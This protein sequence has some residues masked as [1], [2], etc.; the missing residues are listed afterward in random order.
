MYCIVNKQIRGYQSSITS[1]NVVCGPSGPHSELLSPGLEESLLSVSE[2]LYISHMPLLSI[3]MKT[4]VVQHVPR[5]DF[6]SPVR[7]IHQYLWLIDWLNRH[8]D[9]RRQRQS[10]FPDFVKNIWHFLVHNLPLKRQLC[11]KVLT[12]PPSYKNKSCRMTESQTDR[13]AWRQPS[14]KTARQAARLQC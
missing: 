4:K 14:S 13:Q 11:K 7:I 10:W 6:I 8:S 3:D 1:Y 9:S 12:L 5:V 2:T